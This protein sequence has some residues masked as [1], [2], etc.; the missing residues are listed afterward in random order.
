MLLQ[1]IFEFEFENCI[2]ALSSEE[3]APVGKI[4]A[5][6]LQEKRYHLTFVLKSTVILEVVLSCSTFLAICALAS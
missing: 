4:L 3:S 6:P 5:P 1:K 2:L